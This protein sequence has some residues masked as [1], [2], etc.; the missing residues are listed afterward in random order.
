[1]AFVL[2]S[3]GAPHLCGRPAPRRSRHQSRAGGKPRTCC[4]SRWRRTL[5]D[6]P[7]AHGLQAINT[8]THEVGDYMVLDRRP[9]RGVLSEDATLLYVSDTAAGRVTPV[10]I[11]NRRIVRIPEKVSRSRRRFSR[12]FALRSRGNLLLVVSEG[13]A[14]SPSS[15][16]ARIFCFTLIPSAIIPRISPSNCFRRIGLCRVGLPR[17]TGGTTRRPGRIL[18]AKMHVQESF[19]GKTSTGNPPCHS[20]T[21]SLSLLWPLKLIWSFCRA[22]SKTRSNAASATRFGIQQHTRPF[23]TANPCTWPRS[24]FTTMVTSS[25]RDRD[26][27][28]PGPPAPRA[29]PRM[30]RCARRSVLPRIRNAVRAGRIR[31]RASTR[32]AAPVNTIPPQATRSTTY[33]SHRFDIQPPRGA[34][35]N[36]C[37]G[38]RLMGFANSSGATFPQCQ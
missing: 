28:T 15:A 33:P 22:T 12:R 11:F 7:E 13:S 30:D 24:S 5:R 31:V 19:A 34:I 6:S 37:S 35:C 9:T 29:P 36:A 18:F 1:M 3:F 16:C 8:W 20:A 2:E 14:T 38:L 27:E 4:S 23:S 10:D 26:C 21:P 32:H 25:A 17:P